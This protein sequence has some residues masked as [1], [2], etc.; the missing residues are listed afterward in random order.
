MNGLRNTYLKIS[1]YIYPVCILKKAFL[2]SVCLV[3]A[4]MYNNGALVCARLVIASFLK[5]IRCLIKNVI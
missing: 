2:S 3:F 4:C 5:T 1:G